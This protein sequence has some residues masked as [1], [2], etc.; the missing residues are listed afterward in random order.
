VTG[1]KLTLSR[2][3]AER[4]VRGDFDSG[5]LVKALNTAGFHVEVKQ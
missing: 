2:A 3:V 5:E 1:G 4:E